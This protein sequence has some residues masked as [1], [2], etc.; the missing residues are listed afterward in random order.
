VPARVRP[1][2]KDG[3]ATILSIGRM[4]TK[5]GFDPNVV[6]MFSY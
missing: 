6:L 2:G 3:D 4:V 5:E 1:F